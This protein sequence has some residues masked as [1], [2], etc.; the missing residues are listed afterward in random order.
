MV[1][2][3]NIKA[4]KV[5]KSMSIAG[6]C[7]DKL[8]TKVVHFLVVLLLFMFRKNSKQWKGLLSKS[9]RELTMPIAKQQDKAI[10]SILT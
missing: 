6:S 2:K 9:T 5:Q 4:S 10:A 8:R 1:I 7:D 3:G